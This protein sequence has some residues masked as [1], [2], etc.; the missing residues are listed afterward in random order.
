MTDIAGLSD[1]SLGRLHDAII[2]ALE[3]DDASTGK[4]PFEV[5][6]TNDWKIWAKMLE[7]EMENR[8]LNYRN[9]PW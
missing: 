4:K 9:I 5:R 3:I 6:A 2:K 8:S 7:E 1:D